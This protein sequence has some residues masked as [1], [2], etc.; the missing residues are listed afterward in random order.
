[1]S[2]ALKCRKILLSLTSSI[3]LK[4]NSYHFA[5]IVKMYYIQYWGI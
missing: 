4:I 2:K 1:M 5:P 3:Y